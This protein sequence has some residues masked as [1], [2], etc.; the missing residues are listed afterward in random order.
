M[1]QHPPP[2]YPTLPE[3]IGKQD[4]PEI[5]ILRE[6]LLS[7]FSIYLL[8]HSFQPYSMEPRSSS[9]LFALR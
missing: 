3:Q 8:F 7:L 4:L 9:G 1:L 2:P 6:A 5:Y